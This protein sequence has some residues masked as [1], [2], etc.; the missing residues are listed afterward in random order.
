MTSP[1]LYYVMDPMCSW[2]WGFRPVLNELLELLPADT[3][4]RHVMGGL[5]PDTEA[6]M[7]AETRAYVQS[8]WRAVAERC[9]AEFNPEFWVR[10]QPRRST[11][12]ACRAVLATEQQNSQRVATMILAIQKAYYLQ[13]RNP[14]ERGTLIELAVE[15]G[16]DPQRFAAHLDSAMV[17]T[18]L[19][20]DFEL[21]RQLGADHFPSLLLE[22][23]GKQHW[24]TRGYSDLETIRARL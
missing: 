6:Q 14:S 3:R 23:A 5:A 9:G 15:I 16:L 19:Q 8:M 1:I 7:P 22:V 12:P 24:L 21:R 17:Q 4:L 13:A 10:C 18:R 2:C 20:Q 11:W